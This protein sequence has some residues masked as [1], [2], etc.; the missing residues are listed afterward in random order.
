MPAMVASSHSTRLGPDIVVRLAARG[1]RDV[2]GTLEVERAP[3][4]DLPADAWSDPRVPKVTDVHDSAIPLRP[5]A[6]L[7]LC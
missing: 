2:V 3:S 1:V 7:R 4:L 5:P 6:D